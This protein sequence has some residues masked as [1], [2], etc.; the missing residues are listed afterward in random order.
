MH[1]EDLWTEVATYIYEAYDLDSVEN[2][3]I[4]GDGA[5]WIKTGTE[6]IKDSKYVLDHYHLSK[7]VKILTAHL[8]SLDN[9][10]DRKSVV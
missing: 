4:A 5:K 1:P 8:G 9:P 7:Y 10:I 6:I 3:Y 2:I